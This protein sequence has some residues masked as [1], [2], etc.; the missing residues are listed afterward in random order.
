MHSFRDGPALRQPPREFNG[1]SVVIPCL[2]EAESIGAVVDAAF[3]G[4]TSANLP[5]EVLVVDNG[6]ADGSAEIAREHGA[7]VIREDERGYGATLR[8]GSVSARHDVIVMGD[9]DLTYDFTK[10]D[11]LV[12]PILDE[13]VDFVVGNRMRNLRPGSMPPLHKYVGNPALSLMLRFMF[14][15][16]T[17][18]DA[19]CGMRAITKNAYLQ[20][21]CVTTGMEFASEMI[22]RAMDR[23]LR[24]NEVDITYH[25]RIGESKLKSFR[26]G[27][28]H[29]RF[30]L[31]HSP[32]WILLAPG[33]LFWL[34]GM[35][36]V[37][38]ATIGPVS[39]YGHRVNLHS[40]I[41]G[42]I[43]NVI[44]IQLIS[45]GLIAKAYAH[46]SG[47]REDPLIVW[48][49]RKLTFERV[50]IYTL[51]ITLLG[52]AITAKIFIQ[53][54]VSGFGPMDQAKVLFFGMLCLINGTQIWAAGYVLSIL[55][56]PRHLGRFPVDRNPN[57]T[58]E[59]DGL[60]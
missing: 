45:L 56:L 15:N 24:I 44:S 10:L 25:P 34:L 35:A 55:A 53:W 22:V 23:N 46:F 18:R 6:S 59:R 21:G 54:I 57:G 16:H 14:H 49:Y 60:S 7:R 13:E 20:L 33:V 9:G 28:R 58:R 19:H 50:I 1:I 47:F 31:L 29:M 4:I 3:R 26:D 51:P 42:G 48:F 52:L 43:L 8:K 36:I 32:S 41:M 30:M 39:V 12:K 2:D 37:V 17:V 11:E 38:A 40:I 27:W 5:G